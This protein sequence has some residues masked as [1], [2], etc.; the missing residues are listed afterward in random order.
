MQVIPKEIIIA[1]CIAAVLVVG[2]V[3]IRRGPLFAKRMRKPV[4]WAILSVVVVLAA[5]A[6]LRH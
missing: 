3:R 1:L 5:F 6:L 4:E 2:I